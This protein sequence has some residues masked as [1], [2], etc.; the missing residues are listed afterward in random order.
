MV[1]DKD[2]VI[3][4]DTRGDLRGREYRKNLKGVETQTFALLK[5]SLMVTLCL[6]KDKRWHK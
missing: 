1:H 2:A 3:I 5:L 6:L 4:T